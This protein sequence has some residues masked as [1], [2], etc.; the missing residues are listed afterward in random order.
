[1]LKSTKNKS[2]TNM[3]TLTVTIQN[4]VFADKIKAMLSVF[5]NDGVEVF[6][7][8]SFEVSGAEEARDRVQKAILSK[9][10]INDVEYKD[11]MKAF[12]KS[13]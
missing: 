7:K 8:P 4:D 9:E 5:K 12:F 1:M 11:D 3:Q 13:L 6:E 2:E 10:L